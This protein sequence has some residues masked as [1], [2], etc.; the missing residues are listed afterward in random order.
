MPARVP[1]EVSTLSRLFISL[2]SN[3]HSAGPSPLTKYYLIAYNVASC[4]GWGLVLY[5]TLAHLFTAPTPSKLKRIFSS[6]PKP[7]QWLPAALHPLVQRARTAYGPGDVGSVVRLVQTGA[8]LEVVHVLFGMVRSPLVTTA[9]QV[10]SRIY[11]V[12][13]ITESFPAV[14]FV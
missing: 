9:M 1:A 3:D 10:A 4:L 11:L 8:L 6:T 13:G 12:W 7:P 14:S 5:A 2:K